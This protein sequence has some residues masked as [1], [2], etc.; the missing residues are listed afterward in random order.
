MSKVAKGALL[1]GSIVVIGGVA[2]GFALAAQ[3]QAAFAAIY[4]A[5]MALSTSAFL[6]GVSAQLAKSRL[7]RRVETISY[8]GTT[9]P[10]RII[11][12]ERLV[13]GMHCLPP[14]NSGPNSEMTHEVM[15]LSG[16]CENESVTWNRFSSLR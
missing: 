11:F 12:G 15:V 16:H 3:S 6:S 14:L 10:R 8:A 9:E 13:G 1:A 5:T 2:A 4:S 7:P